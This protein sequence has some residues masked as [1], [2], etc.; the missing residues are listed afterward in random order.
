MDRSWKEEG[1]EGG[2]LNLQTTSLVHWM[3]QEAYFPINSFSSLFSILF[4]GNCVQIRKSIPPKPTPPLSWTGKGARTRVPR[5][6]VVLKFGSSNWFCFGFFP[7]SQKGNNACS[8]LI[9]IFQNL[10]WGWGWFQHSRGTLLVEK[11]GL[12]LGDWLVGMPL[13]RVNLHYQLLFLFI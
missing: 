4:N 8:L 5:Q 10:L 11:R 13:R 6:S 3:S 2:V 1:R 9:A 7:L 12:G